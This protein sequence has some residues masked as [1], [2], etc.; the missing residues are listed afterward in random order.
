M[1]SKNTKNL[2]LRILFY[3]RKSEKKIDKGPFALSFVRLIHN[4][5]LQYNDSDDLLV[6]K[7]E[8]GKF[9]EKNLSYLQ[10][11]SKR[12]ELRFNQKSSTNKSEINTIYQ[13]NDKNMIHYKSFFSSAIHTNNQRL[14]NI[15]CWRENEE[16]LKERIKDFIASGDNNYELLKFLPNFLDSLFQIANHIPQFQINV[17]DAIVYIIRLCDEPKYH[18]FKQILDNYIINFYSPDA[19]IFIL[20]NLTWYIENEGINQRGPDS[21]D[22]LLPVLKSLSLLMR[23]IVISKKCGDLIETKNVLRNF[24]SKLDKLLESLALLMQ[25]ELNQ[26]VT[27]QNAALKY[28]PSIITPLIEYGIYSPIWL[29]KYIINVMEKLSKQILICYKLNFLS[30][31]INTDLFACKDCRKI[32]L[33]KFLKELLRFMLPSLKNNLDYCVQLNN[34]N[35]DGLTEGIQLSAKIL[36]DIVEKLF[37]YSLSHSVIQRGTLNELTLILFECIRPLNQTVIL[38]LNN[39]NHRVVYALLMALLDKFSAYNYLYYFKTM[40][41]N[42]AKLDMLSRFYNIFLYKN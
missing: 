29:S 26:R 12:Q 4:Y 35:A 27:C 16:L 8:A 28:L 38:L 13:Q 18:Q 17:F 37:P 21:R 34:S 2:H 25:G 40:K 42:I 19:Y 11:Y 20:Q 6:Y 15:F 14:L 41:T 23:L 3:N 10:N 30:D 22:L 33:P 7:I 5:V 36:T 32:L 39:P 24:E 9:D 31:V 1:P